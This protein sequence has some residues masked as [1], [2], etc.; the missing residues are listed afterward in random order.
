MFYVEIV[1]LGM[2]EKKNGIVRVAHLLTK[3]RLP[4]RPLL[5]LPSQAQQSQ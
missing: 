1:V 2:R 4:T 3:N 5:F